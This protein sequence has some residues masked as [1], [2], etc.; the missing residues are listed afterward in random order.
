MNVKNAIA[1]SLSAVVIATTLFA[2]SAAAKYASSP[3]APKPTRVY[4]GFSDQKQACPT[5]QNI[6]LYVAGNGEGWVQVRVQRKS[7]GVISGPMA[8]KLK[9]KKA[10]GL[11]K[12]EYRGKLF[13]KV[14]FGA[15]QDDKYRAIVTGGGKTKK[16]DYSKLLIK[17]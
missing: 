8:L 7:D 14:M 12:D 2:S 3:G 9:K 16:S 11:N 4:I 15:S 5:P 1:A 6:L 13:W 10:K 17:C